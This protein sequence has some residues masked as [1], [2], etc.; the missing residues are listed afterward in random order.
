MALCFFISLTLLIDAQINFSKAV[1]LVSQ[2]PLVSLSNSL[3]IANSDFA[4]NSQEIS[5]H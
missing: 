2:T 3:G 4:E 5:E 1:L